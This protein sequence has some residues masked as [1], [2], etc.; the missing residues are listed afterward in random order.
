MPIT[1]VDGREIH[2][3]IVPENTN[4][5]VSIL[6]CNRDPTLWGLVRMEP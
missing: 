1:G 6:N 4:V 2:E 5:I 3:I